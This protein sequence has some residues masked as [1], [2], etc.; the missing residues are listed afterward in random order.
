[1]D[2]EKVK[3]SLEAAGEEIVSTATLDSLPP[4][5][6]DAFI[7][8]GLRIDA[9]EPG[10][11]LCSMTVPP[12]LLN[13]GNF[14]HGGATA[15]LV[16]VMGSAAIL[17]AGTATTS[18]VSLEISISYLDSAFAHE[19]IEIEGKVLRAGKAV[20]VATVEIRKKKTGK[21]IAQARHTKYLAAASKL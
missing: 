17:S 7:L 15:S 16:D 8:K 21:L 19:E 20:A 5:F 13:T 10:R 4:R 12:R 9:I 1:M 3:R 11:V 6:Y 14:L 2:L 18:G